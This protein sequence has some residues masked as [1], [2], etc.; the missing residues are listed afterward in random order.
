M[1]AGRLLWRA[2][3]PLL[4][5]GCTAAPAP[6]PVIEPVPPPSVPAAEAADGADG[7]DGARVV[8]S[9]EICVLEAGDLAGVRAD[10]LASGD[11][12]VAGRPFSQVYADTGQYVRSRS[13]Y[14]DNEPIDYDPRDICFTRYG[15][16]RILERDSLVRLGAWRGV[17]VFAE[18]ASGDDPLVI[19]VPVSPGCEFQPYQTEAIAPPPSC[20]LPHRFVV[21]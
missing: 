18:R 6:V 4:F 12:V 21:P 19:Y 13:W 20:P 5:A 16:P 8:R 15:L 11:T 17:P 1:R 9:I 7:A 2:A 14:R 10:L 3:G